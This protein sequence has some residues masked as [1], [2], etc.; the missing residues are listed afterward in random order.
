MAWEALDPAW[1]AVNSWGP[2][3]AAGVEEVEVGVAVAEDRPERWQTL[4]PPP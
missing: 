3:G 4:S 1:D 2:G